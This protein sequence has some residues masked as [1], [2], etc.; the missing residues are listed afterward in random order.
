MD[1]VR[2]LVAPFIPEGNRIECAAACLAALQRL[3]QPCNDTLTRDYQEHQFWGMGQL[4]K[5]QAQL[6]C[7]LLQPLF[8]GVYVVTLGFCLEAL[9]R[10]LEPNHG[11]TQLEGTLSSQ[12]RKP[13]DVNKPM[14]VVAILMAIIATLDVVITFMIGWRAFTTADSTTSAEEIL[15]TDSGWINIVGVRT[16]LFCCIYTASAS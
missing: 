2:I 9:L 8:Y 11:S 3:L 5:V 7:N 10:R 6:L 15:A 12:W 14:L 1:L 4:S 13:S 16:G